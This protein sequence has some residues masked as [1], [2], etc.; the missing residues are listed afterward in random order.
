MNNTGSIQN[1]LPNLKKS[2]DGTYTKPDNLVDLFE[3]SVQKYPDNR[4]FGTKN[5]VGEY[6]WVTY[7]SVAERVD[8]VRGGLFRLG[9]TKN[10]VVGIIAGNRTEWMVCAY[11]TYG[12]EARFV[13]MY[14]KEL[15]SMWQYIIRDSA[16]KVLLVSSA[17][18]YETVKDFLK[19]IPTLKKIFVI[20][21]TGANSLEELENEG[22]SHPVPSKKPSSSDIAVLIYTSGTT[23]EPKGVLLSHG[24]LTSCSQAGWHLFSELNE[25][26]VSLSHLPW[27]HS[28]GLSAEL[29][30]WLQF[31]GAIAFMGSLE[32]LAADMQKAHP[33]YLISVPRMFNKIYSKIHETMREAG[34]LKQKLFNMALIAAKEK[35]ETGKAGFKY[36]LLDKAVFGKIRH[37]FGGKLQGALTASAKMNPDVAQFFFDIGIP[38]YDCYGM[39]ET[40]PAVTM[41]HHSQYRHGSVGKPLEKIDVVIDKS[42]VDDGSDDGEIIIYGPNVMQGYYNK[43]EK[44]KE[45]MTPDGGVRS[46]DRGRLDK[47]G[48][49]F[50]TG[51]FK[52]EYK[53]ENGKYVFPTEIEE[54]MKL[55]PYVA[56]V[57]I[58]GDGKPY[59]VALIYPNISVMEHIARDLK[60]SVP[61]KELLT[62]KEMMKLVT[63]GIGNHLRKRFGGY[64]IPNRIA[65]LDEDFTVENGLLTQTMKPKRKQIMKKYESLLK[66]LYM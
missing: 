46:G 14:E 61:V 25:H 32:S 62:N 26:S 6:E 24:N 47:D 12:L 60:F 2:W 65:F 19:N 59:N 45:I 21:S 48:F 20:E 10:D 39:T 30:N 29:N 42:K 34:G 40:S 33:T 27:A 57:M 56:N 17:E 58:Y 55:L 5:A 23:G 41:S 16:I 35:R 18:I 53:L 43:P 3:A 54:E 52:E 49:L 31:G 15:V 44:T 1:D 9:L 63:F 36:R 7:K 22:K 51:R 8:H 13:P 37:M 11:A 28:Y 38:V 50:I 66:D 64:E 4:C